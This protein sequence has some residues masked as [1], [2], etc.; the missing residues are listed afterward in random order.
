MAKSLRRKTV[1]EKFRCR[2]CGVP[3]HSDDFFK[4]CEPDLDLNGRMCICKDCCRGILESYVSI[5]GGI[6]ERGFLRACKKLNILYDESSIIK[7]HEKMEELKQSGKGPDS[8]FGTYLRNLFASTSEKT[9]LTFQE[10]NISITTIE[11]S[12]DSITAKM[13]V[14]ENEWGKGLS[15]DDYVFLN[16]E[17]EKWMATHRYETRGEQT[18]LKEIVYKELELRNARL[19]PNTPTDALLKQLQ[20]L[21]KTA[22][23]NEVKKEESIETLG[24][25]I[26]IMETSYP[27]DFYKDKDLYKDYDNISQYFDKH[28]TR[29]ILNFGT[30]SRDFNFELEDEKD[31]EEEDDINLEEISVSEEIDNK[32]E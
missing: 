21:M 1:E 28:V 29:P 22:K 26:R 30:N 25:I 23:T 10:P 2:K 3:K 20:E 24:S 8:L 18:L 19:N 7:T 11:D 31:E 16:E 9:E 6:I 12:P 17:L 4:T 5:E 27:A 32:E 14:W 15:Y 13:S